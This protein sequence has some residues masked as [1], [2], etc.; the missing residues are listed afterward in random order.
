MANFS[1]RKG[2]I[3]F[4]DELKDDAATHN[5]SYLILCSI[6]I[7]VRGMYESLA[8]LALFT[9]MYGMAAAKIEKT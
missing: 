3:R 6:S 9:F 7:E 5:F 1:F 2:P 4:L 8:F